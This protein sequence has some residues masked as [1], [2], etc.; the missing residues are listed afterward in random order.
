MAVECR[1]QLSHETRRAQRPTATAVLAQA[2]QRCR[3]EVIAQI[4]APVGEA[5]DQRPDSDQ[6]IIAAVQVRAGARPDPVLGPLGQ[7]GADRV[8]LDVTRR[9]R[10]VGLVQWERVKPLLPQRTAPPLALVDA[11]GV[12]AMR[13]AERR[14]EAIGMAR[15]QDQVDV[16]GHQAIGPDLGR[17]LGA[18][19]GQKPEVGLVVGLPEECI[20]APVAPLGDVVRA[21]RCDHAS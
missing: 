16:V 17:R 15:Y 21:T 20:Q 9:R 14:A 1:L 19:L 6:R 13:L 4:A 7:A 18:G 3:V 12:A 2:V 10:Q 8:A 11:P 5:L